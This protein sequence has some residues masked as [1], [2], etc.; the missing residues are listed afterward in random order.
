MRDE[1]VD[2]VGGFSANFGIKVETTRLK[3]SLLYYHLQKPCRYHA[4]DLMGH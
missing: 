2:N 3:A 1:E 4:L